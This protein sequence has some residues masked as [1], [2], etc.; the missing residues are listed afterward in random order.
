MTLSTDVIISGTRDVDLHHL[1]FGGNRVRQM[2]QMQGSIYL[3]KPD[4]ILAQLKFG[5]P[6]QKCRVI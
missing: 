6:G 3:S 1:R 2:L 4:G 5:L